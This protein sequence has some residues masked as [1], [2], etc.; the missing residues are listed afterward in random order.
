MKDAGLDMLAVLQRYGG[1]YAI[2]AHEGSDRLFTIRLPKPVESIAL[3]DVLNA[4][5]N[6]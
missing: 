4:A 6:A 5:L 3:A 1:N 2:V